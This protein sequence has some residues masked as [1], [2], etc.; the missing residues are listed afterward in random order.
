MT[1]IATGQLVTA[2]QIN[3]WCPV[4]TMV[5][6][7]GMVAPNGWFIGDGSAVS[8]IS[9][10]ELFAAACPQLVGTTAN[11][12]FTI[13]GLASTRGL[14]AGMPVEGPGIPAAT[15]IASVDSTTQVTVSNRATASATVTLQ[16][17]L[18]G[19]GD[20]STTFN[21]PDARGRMAV[22]W[23]ASGGHADVSGL[24]ANDGQAVLY[25]RPKHRTSN[26]LSG[27]A[28]GLS[29]TLPNHGH[30]F[31]DPV[32]NLQNLGSSGGANAHV[33]GAGNAGTGDVGSASTGV[34]GN[35]TSLPSISVS[36]TVTVSGTVGTNV[37]T[38]ALDSPSYIVL[39]KIIRA[40][41]V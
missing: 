30:S 22:G 17:F 37:S 35:P 13:T 18:F 6:Y 14:R 10:P 8:R 23:A 25:R 41:D 19:N 33:S 15:T 20:G 36:G 2:D 39:T 4:G 40:K 5:D 27:S 28:S 7:I 11:G 9:W 1:T 29:G 32:A 26:S 34:V 38:D 16:F 24:G 3:Q 31:T 21:L 12:S